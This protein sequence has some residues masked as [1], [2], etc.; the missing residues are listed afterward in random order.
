MLLLMAAHLGANVAAVRSLCLPTLNRPRLRLTLS[1]ALRGGRGPSPPR[2]PAPNAGDTV[3]VTVPTPEEVNPR[4]PLLPGFGARLRLHLG[5]PLHL[6]VT[7]EAEFRKAQECG[8]RDYVVVLRPAQ[9]WVGVGLRDGAP[10]D[11]PLRGCAQAL[12]L[13]ELLGPDL[14]PGAPM[15]AALRPLQQRLRRC[16]PGSVPWA[17]LA[18]ISRVWATLG[19]AFLR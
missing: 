2:G 13:E 18:E 4:E 12:L 5:A 6:L 8:T 11:A 7:S 3:T 15:G 10:P 14:P 19:P 9:G 16:P 1:A 17:T